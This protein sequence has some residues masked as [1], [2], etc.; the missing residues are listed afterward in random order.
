[1]QRTSLKTFH[2]HKVI[3]TSLLFNTSRRS[4]GAIVKAD[5]DHKFLH[6]SLNKKTMILD[7]LKPV[8]PQVIVLENQFRHLNDLPF[9][10]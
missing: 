3:Q 7:G 5:G 9:T 1:M 8:A 10:Q 6:P 2:L 4:L